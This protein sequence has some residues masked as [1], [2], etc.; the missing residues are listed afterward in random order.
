MQ[1]IGAEKIAQSGKFIVI[2]SETGEGKTT[3]CYQSLPGK[4]LNII[5]EPRNPTGAIEASGR[6]PADIDIVR[7]TDWFELLKFLSEIISNPARFDKYTSV[8]LDSLSFLMNVSL[9]TEIENEA[10]EAKTVSEKNIKPIVNMAKMSLEGFGGMSSQM[11]R[12]M[13]MLG[14]VSAIGKVVVVTCL[15]DERPKWNRELSAAPALAG[16]EF[17]RNF[18]GF[19]DLIG[20]VTSRNIKVKQEDGTYK[21]KRVFPPMVSFEG[22]GSFLCKFSGPRPEGIEVMQGPLD[23]SKILGTIKK[24]EKAE[25][26]KSKKEGGEKEKTQEVKT[27]QEVKVNE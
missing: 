17:P 26:E 5:T 22:D 8:F 24:A 19:V 18:P 6:D 16:R 3:S 12:L 13:N 7:Y 11:S 4:I 2:Y 21:D 15:L 27:E 20:L 1:I 9:S 10:Y 23:F 14:R 25:N